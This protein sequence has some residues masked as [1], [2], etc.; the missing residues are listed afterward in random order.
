MDLVKPNNKKDA[1]GMSDA[2]IIRFLAANP[3]AVRRPIIDTGKVLT[4]GF[5]PE[6]RAKLA[7]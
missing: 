2:E 5:T 7:P 4:L 1:E 6:A 3:N